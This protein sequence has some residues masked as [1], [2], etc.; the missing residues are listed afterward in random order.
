MK[1]ELALY[2]LLSAMVLPAVS[3][4]SWIHENVR[5]NDYL[6]GWRLADFLNGDIILL[7]VA[8]IAPVVARDLG[9]IQVPDSLPF[10]IAAVL[11]ALLP[12]RRTMRLK[13]ISL[14][15]CLIGYFLY[16]AIASEISGGGQKIL[17]M[18]ETELTDSGESPESNSERLTSSVSAI[19]TAVD[20]VRLLFVIMAGA[21][22]GIK[23]ERKDKES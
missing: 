20:G 1:S 3:V 2:A 14:A 11:T 21:F 15:L 16:A 12:D 4:Y 18:L 7:N 5:V 6:G 19:T 23:V 22:M 9:V 17:A 13:L 8:K 10:A